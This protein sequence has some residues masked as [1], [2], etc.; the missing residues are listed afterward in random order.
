MRITKWILSDG[1]TFWTRVETVTSSNPGRA[2]FTL[3]LAIFNMLQ[4]INIIIII[5]IIIVSGGDDSCNSNS[6]ITLFLGGTC[7]LN[8]YYVFFEYNLKDLHYRHF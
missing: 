8:I 6:R 3:V 4:S 7:Y 2:G 1:L 5:I